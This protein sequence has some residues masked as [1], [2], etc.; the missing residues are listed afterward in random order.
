MGQEEDENLKHWP[1]YGKS[2]QGSWSRK[3]LTICP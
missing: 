3:I 2:A 1:G